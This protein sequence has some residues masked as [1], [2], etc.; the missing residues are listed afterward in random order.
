MRW[1]TSVSYKMEIR[2]SI[3]EACS[4]YNPE[5]YNKKAKISDDSETT[6]PAPTADFLPTPAPSSSAEN[7]AS[8]HPEDNLRND[9]LK[10]ETLSPYVPYAQKSALELAQ[11]AN[12]LVSNAWGHGQGPN[13]TDDIRAELERVKFER[14]QTRT[15]NEM[16]RVERD[17]EAK[18]CL[19]LRQE[20]DRLKKSVKDKARKSDT[21]LRLV[22]ASLQ[23]L[24]ADA[25]EALEP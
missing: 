22:T 17:A 23:S 7:V 8:S 9:F 16:L 24:Q 6:G 25:V 13:A 12:K 18:A 11:E 19:E 4:E 10:R 21:V 1:Q 14:D 3:T 20:L 5:P 15:E 2:L